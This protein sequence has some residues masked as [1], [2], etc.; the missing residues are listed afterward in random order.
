MEQI[1]DEP[2]LGFIGYQN[3]NT[4]GRIILDWLEK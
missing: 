3:I 2:H 1:E 4:N